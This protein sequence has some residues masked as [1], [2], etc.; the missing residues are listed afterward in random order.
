[1]LNPYI[2]LKFRP[3]YRQTIRHFLLQ[4][5]TVDFSGDRGL[6]SLHKRLSPRHVCC[7]NHANIN[8][9]HKG[10]KVNGR[11]TKAILALVFFDAGGG[12]RLDGDRP[13]PPPPLPHPFWQNVNDFN[14][15]CV[16]A[17][18]HVGMGISKVCTKVKRKLNSFWFQM[19][20]YAQARRT[21]SN[22]EVLF[23]LTRWEPSTFT[24]HRHRL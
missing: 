17:R 12:W 22:F 1:M 24:G 16:R 5:T 14:V 9:L 23:Y 11:Q 3:S 4:R 10:Y 8:A 13:I 20:V 7:P 18:L 21:S 6:Q 15:H 2:H 19:K